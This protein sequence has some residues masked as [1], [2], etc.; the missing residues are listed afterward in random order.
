MKIEGEAQLLR[1][2]LGD[3]DR[4]EGKPLFQAIVELARSKGLAGATVLKG[5]IGYGANSRIHTASILRLSEDLPVV[6]E[7][8]D[9]P[10]KIASILPTLDG[11]LGEGLITL[12][13]VRVITY[14][15]GA[16]PAL[17]IGGA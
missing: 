12:E 10:E 16:G 5:V 8:V 14:R 13:K 9:V 1:I 3:G 11:M 15:H 7:I 4:Y 6:V 2:F 17:G